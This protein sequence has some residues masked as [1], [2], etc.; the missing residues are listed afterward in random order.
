MGIRS[1][2]SNSD[3]YVGEEKPWLGT[4]CV[5]YCVQFW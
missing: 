1:T 2:F 4:G 5:L 3:V